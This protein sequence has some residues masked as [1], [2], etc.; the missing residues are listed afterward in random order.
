MDDRWI[1][2]SD[3]P[4]SNHELIVRMYRSWSG[5]KAFAVKIENVHVE[6]CTCG[7]IE[8]PRKKDMEEEAV[9]T[10]I[11][12]ESDTSRFGEIDDKFAKEMVL[13]VFKNVLEVDL[14]GLPDE[15]TNG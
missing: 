9:I 12:R 7:E 3:G 2:I 5:F 8:W 4:N 15:E 6:L 10:K 13:G 11:I 1:I 14:I